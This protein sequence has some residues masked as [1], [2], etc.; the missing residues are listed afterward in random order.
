VNNAIS[1]KVSSWADDTQ[2]GFTLG[3]QGIDNIVALDARARCQ[4]HIAASIKDLPVAKHP[5]LILFDFC[6]AFPSV[7]HALIFMILDALGL[8]EGLINYFKALYVDNACYACLDGDVIFLYNILSG[9]I[10]GCPAS[11]TIVVMVADPFLRSLK[12]DIKGSVSR[13]YA[14]DIGTLIDQLLKLRPLHSS[15]KL[16]ERISGLALKPTK[17]VIIPLGKPPTISFFEAVKEFLREQ[18][19]EWT[20]FDVRDSAEYLGMILGP[21]GGN[22]ASWLKP[23]KNHETAHTTS[24]ALTSHHPSAPTY[25][26]KKLPQ[27][28]HTFRSCMK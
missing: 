26:I 11:G 8:P 4:D 2:N 15:F 22:N 25:I 5:A 27:L 20:T 19:P 9:I 28:L 12:N 21:G 23:L 1:K 24:R 6:A 14:D 3:R 7:A 13:A 16:F 18:V 10:Q 17:C